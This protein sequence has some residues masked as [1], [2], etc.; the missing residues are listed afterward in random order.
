MEKNNSLSQNTVVGTIMT[1]KALEDYFLEKKINLI[2]TD[3]GDR[4]IIQS[5]KEQKICFRWRTIWSYYF[6]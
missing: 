2:R 1:N 4:N 5:M 3:V 6:R